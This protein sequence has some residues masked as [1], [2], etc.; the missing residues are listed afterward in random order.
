MT[1]K[2]R[3]SASKGAKTSSKECVLAFDLGGTKLAAGI[4]DAGGKI[5]EETRVP[6]SL[7]LGKDA[8]LQQISDAG[9]ALL[10]GFP[11]VKK[12]G[13]ASAGPLDARTGTLLDPMNFTSTREG[14]WGKVPLASI[15]KKRLKRP[16]WVENDADAAILAEAWL[17]AARHQKDAMILTLG[18]GLGTGILVDGKLVQA[19]Q[20]MHPE[21]G[22]LTL[23][24]D[25]PEVL[26]GCGKRGCAEAFL[27]GKGFTERARKKIGQSKLQGEDVVKLAQQ[28]N[29]QALQLFADYAH[30]LAMA[31]HTY[32]MLYC[33][34][35]IIFAG[36]FAKASDFFLPKAT[37]ELYQ[38]LCTR[39]NWKN[40]M[41]K[42]EVSKLENR[43]G[44]LGAAYIAL[45]GKTR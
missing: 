34:K 39:E 24:I 37:A 6:V 3:K 15:L 40:M 17:G 20:G 31:L 23:R 18:T 7:E 14:S 29:A 9:L 43:S 8:V 32:V 33:P 2:A 25:D 21:A 36:S 10:S 44:L 13:M 16:V 1:H 41:P 45:Q 5:L 19:G 12:V 4:V 11:K 35:V 22:H 28:R 42:L 26:C 30:L 38:L 27:S